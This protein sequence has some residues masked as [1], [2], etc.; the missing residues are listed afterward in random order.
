MNM[1]VFSRKPGGIILS[2]ALCTHALTITTWMYAEQRKPILLL[3]VV[4]CGALI[5]PDID[6]YISINIFLS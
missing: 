1:I 3:L 5:L 4:C 6:Y 2:Y